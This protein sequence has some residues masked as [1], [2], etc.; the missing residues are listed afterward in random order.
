MSLDVCGSLLVLCAVLLVLATTE[1]PAADQLDAARIEAVT[2]MLP[3]TPVGLG[4]RINDR[5]AWAKL[6]QIEALKQRAAQAD[7]LLTE[8]LPEQPDDLFLEFSRTGNRTH[9]QNVSGKRRGRLTPLVLAECLENKGRFLPAL[10]ELLK[11][12]CAEKTWV[13]PAHDGKLMNFEGR[14]VDIDLAS[15]ALGWQLATADWLLGDKLAPETRTLLRERINHFVVEPYLAQIR[16]K[17]GL[18][19]WLKTTNNWNAVCLAGV[20][21]TCLV[22]LDSPADRAEVVVA[23]DHYSRN[24][25]AGFPSDGYCTEG[26]GYW[27]YGF[28]NYVLL[29]ETIWQAT[30]GKDDPF[31]RPESRMP[32]QF[33]ARIQII[34]G[35]APAFADCGVNARPDPTTMWYGNK[36]F[37]LGFAEYDKL[38][39]GWV[40]GSLTNAMLFLMPNSTD[41]P[42]AATADT[43]LGLRTWFDQAG[44]LI[45]RPAPNSDCAMGVALKGGNNNEH[46]NHNDVGSY[47]VVVGNRP[48][49]LDPGAEVYTRRTFSAQRYESKLLNSYGHPVPVIAGKLQEPGADHKAKVLRADFTDTTDTLELDITSAY[50]VPELKSLVRTFVYSRAGKGSLKVTD[51]VVY[52]SPQTFATA[53][54]TLGKCEPQGDKTLLIYDTDQAAKVDL[55]TGGQ[56]F[57]LPTE[58]IMEDGAHP[59]RVGINLTNPVAEATVT[60]TITPAEGP[61]G[62]D[63]GGLLRNGGFEAGDWFWSLSGNS[64]GEVTDEQAAS[65]KFSLKITDPGPNTGSNINSGQIPVEG[66][67]KYLLRGKVF[68]VAGSGIGLYVM[69]RDAGGKTLNPDD[70]NGNI[71]PVGS[72]SG[73]V[74]QWVPFSFPFETTKDTKTV[75]LWIHSFNGATVTAYLDDL[76][77]V[78]AP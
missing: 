75:N 39:P 72:L 38:D 25:L 11:A 1:G 13:M 64:L 41:K 28:G 26:L 68:H 52:N 15:S 22:M 74:G 42:A 65:G 5:A 44:I 12:L 23:A 4:P 76:E 27:D 71:A 51:H 58:R 14:G 7:K 46:H 32:A 16:G 19:W 56:A 35:V 21:G 70:A 78:K 10:E 20:T 31:L 67:A 45:G 6:G 77:I 59:L 8:P 69:L 2:K 54:L 62:S 63:Q 61:A 57:T 73:A 34:G 9:W 47:V 17:T 55:D 49:L 66:G 36:R 60:V 37:G 40:A 50:A 3:E 18:N 43:S 24:F 33:G 30:G 48:V 29:C 53:V